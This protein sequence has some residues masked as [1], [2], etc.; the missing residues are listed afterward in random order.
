MADWLQV[1]VRGSGL[2]LRPV[3]RTPALSVTQKRRCSCSMQL[4]AL[5]KCYMPLPCL[6]RDEGAEFCETDVRRRRG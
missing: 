5:C 2:A 3:D 1:K 4:L 6:C